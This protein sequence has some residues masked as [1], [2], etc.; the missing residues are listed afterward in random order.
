MF[1]FGSD[2]FHANVE[3]RI[4]QYTKR[5]GILLD[6]SNAGTALLATAVF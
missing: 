4:G 1:Q 5:R 6:C 3:R 2:C